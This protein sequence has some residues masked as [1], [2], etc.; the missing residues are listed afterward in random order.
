MKKP[1]TQSVEFSCHAPKAKAVFVVGTFNDWKPNASPLHNHQPNGKW[2]VTLPLPPGHHNSSSSWMGNGAAN[3]VASTTIEAVPN[4][5][6]MNS[7][8]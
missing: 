4:A 1:K 7:A 5:C 2:T 3:P 8:R 6:R